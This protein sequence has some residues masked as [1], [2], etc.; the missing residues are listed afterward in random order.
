MYETD[1]DGII[2]ATN[3]DYL[4]KDKSNDLFKDSHNDPTLPIGTYVIEETKAPTGYLIPSC[5][6]RTYIEVVEPLDSPVTE[7]VNTYNKLVYKPISTETGKKS[8]GTSYTYTGLGWA[9][10]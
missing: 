10:W 6:K 9:E 1:S 2:F 7:H 4:V 5:Q 8:D 3:E